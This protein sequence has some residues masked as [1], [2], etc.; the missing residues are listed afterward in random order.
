MYRL[1]LSQCPK[2]PL[3]LRT[4]ATNSRAQRLDGRWPGKRAMRRVVRLEQ[5]TQ[6]LLDGLPRS[7]GNRVARAHGHSP[8][9]VSASTLGFIFMGKTRGA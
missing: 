1:S 5:G 9:S 6:L 2:V 4:A 7:I 8:S 3:H